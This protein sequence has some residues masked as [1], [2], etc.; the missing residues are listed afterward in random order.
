[1]RDAEKLLPV[2]TEVWVKGTV[3]E[4]DMHGWGDSNYKV[5][6]SASFNLFNIWV[7]NTDIKEVE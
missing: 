6:V 7:L 3:I 2:G 5:Q 1:M 4:V